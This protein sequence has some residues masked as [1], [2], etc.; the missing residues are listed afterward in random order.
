M[1][2]LESRSHSEAATE[3]ILVI[4]AWTTSCC[5]AT[6]LGADGEFCIGENVSA[7]C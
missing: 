3:L 2:S 1:R 5:A 7:H 4:T 6:H